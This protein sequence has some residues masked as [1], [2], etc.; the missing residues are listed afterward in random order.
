LL[1]GRRLFWLFVAVAGFVAG[2][3][4][5][6]YVLPHQTE[7]FTLVVGLAFGLLGALLA[8]FLQKLAIAIAGFAAGGYLATVFCAPLLGAATINHPAAWICFLIGGI[9][10]A[11]F[12]NFFFNWALII[13][14][15]LEG[16][17]IILKQLIPHR[18][19]FVI[20]MAVLALVGIFVQS[21]TYRKPARTEE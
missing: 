17:H 10:G 8:F 6:P 4:A 16:S 13:L 9:L 12:M 7:L 15:S 2:V 20:F 19:Y 18:D 11:V 5:V 21:S 1:A 14:S 3:E